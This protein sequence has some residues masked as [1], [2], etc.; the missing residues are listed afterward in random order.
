MLLP[1]TACGCATGGVGISTCGLASHLRLTSSNTSCFKSDASCRP[2]ISTT[3]W[4]SLTM[5][6]IVSER[7]FDATALSTCLIACKLHPNHKASVIFKA[8]VKATANEEEEEKKHCSWKHTSSDTVFSIPSEISSCLADLT[9][10]S[11]A[12][13][14]VSE[15][16]NACFSIVRISRS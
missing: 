12:L 14:L 16:R 1:L 4:A 11:K 13:L 15:G 9:E 2:S 8:K 6:G 7:I 3:F 5:L 10:S